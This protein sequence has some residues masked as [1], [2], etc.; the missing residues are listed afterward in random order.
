[1]LIRYNYIDRLKGFTILLVIMGHLI[2][3]CFLLS[4]DMICE[5]IYSFHMPLFF[6]LSGL[7][8]TPPNLK[9]LFHKFKRLM[10][11]FF[12]VGFL[13]ILFTHRDFQTGIY[14]M[15]KYGFWYLCTLFCYYIFLMP[16]RTI[17]TSIKGGII[18]LILTIA[19]EFF[20]INLAR[21]TKPSTSHDLFCI[22]QLVQYW[23]FFIL[24]FFSEKYNLVTKINTYIFG[25][26]LIL[27]SLLFALYTNGNGH[28]YKIMAIM[29]IIALVYLFYIRESNNSFSE[30]EL[31]F[32]GKGCLDIYLFHNFFLP[33]INLQVLGNWFS[34]TGNYFIEGLF[35][36]ITSISI[37]YLCLFIGNVIRKSKLL[38]FII[39]GDKLF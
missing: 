10:F 26:A 8:A 14:S 20:L 32:F 2:Q 23:P 7:V 18:D 17:P 3:K 27:Y 12:V 37:A 30:N 21:L 28:V 36:V 35:L 31:S 9:K 6:F 5:S 22:G 39:Y 13:Y 16:F 19:I 24:G 29:A 11:P 34:Q 38:S 4:G 1:M 25:I 15:Y 33:I